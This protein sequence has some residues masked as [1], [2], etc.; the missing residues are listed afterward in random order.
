[1]QHIKNESIWTEKYRPE[2]V[3]SIILPERIK[4]QF[5]D[6]VKGDEIP[7]MLFYGSSGT[8]KTT[9]AK[10]LCKEMG[11]DWLVLN[12]SEET[13]IDVLRTKIRDFAST[14]SLTENSGKR[15]VVVLDECLEENERVRIGTI[16]NWKA[17]SLKNL[18]WGVN[19]P[20]VSFNME[21]D[22]F[23]NDTCEIISEKEDDIYEVV[24]DNGS[25][26][27]LNE[28]HPFIV[29]DLENNTKELSI[30]QGLKKGSMVVVG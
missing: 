12:M 16:D 21:T 24:L 8:G 28:N 5:E 6:I 3:E 26:I 7:N 10:A 19:Y 1:M 14:L 9:L 4:S 17:V 2:K 23:E 25:K 15:K 22:K 18:E 20:V 30:S 29:K 11:V 27:Y 13:G